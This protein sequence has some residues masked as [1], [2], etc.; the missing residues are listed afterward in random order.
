MPGK[1]F[2]LRT[3]PQE[4]AN[5][6]DT[7][8]A[9]LAQRLSRQILEGRPPQRADGPAQALALLH[10]L[11]HIRQAAERLQRNAASDAVRAGAGYPQLGDACGITRQGAR[12]RWPGPFDHLPDTPRSIR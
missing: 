8:V 4:T 7:A 1:N 5:V 11:D 3:S 9:D 12:R 6:M 10:L 2:V